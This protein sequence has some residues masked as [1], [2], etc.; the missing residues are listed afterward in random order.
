MTPTSLSRKSSI[1]DSL[2]TSIE[3][4]QGNKL[5]QEED[6][7][8]Q[9]FQHSAR[10]SL[11]RSSRQ[12][13]EELSDDQS[14]TKN[15]EDAENNLETTVSMSHKSIETKGYIFTSDMNNNVKQWRATDFS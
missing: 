3:Q 12:S 5:I 4:V 15:K 13:I 7:P 2:N 1:D 8:D 11:T 14:M 10:R 9:I 6:E